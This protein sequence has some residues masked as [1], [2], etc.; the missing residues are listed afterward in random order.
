M[1]SLEDSKGTKLVF[2][3]SL[4]SDIN[5]KNFIFGICA[6]HFNGRWAA[7]MITAPISVDLP[8]GLGTKG[9]PPPDKDSSDK[10]R[11]MDQLRDDCH[12]I[13]IVRGLSPTLLMSP[14]H[15]WTPI[16]ANGHQ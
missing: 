9:P 5:C 13:S 8:A 6:L 12:T 3:F 4:D 10:F 2:F 15:Q 11:K 1:A 14:E 16:D 7:A